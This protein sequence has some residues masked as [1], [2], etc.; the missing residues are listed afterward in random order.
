[1]SKVEKNA[2]LSNLSHRF[3]QFA[4]VRIK[5]MARGEISELKHLLDDV[6]LE[7]QGWTFKGE[8]VSR[9]SHYVTEAWVQDNFKD[10]EPRFFNE[11]IKGNRFGS[12][13]LNVPV[14][15]KKS[16]EGE[17]VW[18]GAEK[19]L[20]L[21]ESNTCVFSC[22]AS[23]LA[24]IGD[25]MA[26]KR[27]SNLV[28]KSLTGVEDRAKMANLVL[29]NTIRPKNAPRLHYECKKIKNQSV[30]DLLAVSGE[31]TIVLLCLSDN[32]CICMVGKHIV[33]ANREYTLPR[34]MASIKAV[35]ESEVEVTLHRGGYI[36]TK[37]K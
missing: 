25:E 29:G 36:F 20:Y 28:E 13:Y 32:H 8:D 37:V 15:T 5:R 35:L 17:V 14:G 6:G 1:M 19:I 23:A 4:I 34:N 24:L 21:Q 30:G 2:L 22:L 10:K 7:D 9:R 11:L 16:I 26:A 27:I 31:K 12:E 3:P 18:D 33:D